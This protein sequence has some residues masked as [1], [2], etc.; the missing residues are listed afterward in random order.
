MEYVIQVTVIWVATPCS[1]V[2]GY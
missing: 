1:S 2:V